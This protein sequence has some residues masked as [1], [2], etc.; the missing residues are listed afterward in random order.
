MEGVQLPPWKLAQRL[1]THLLGRVSPPRGGPLVPVT[2]G[3]VWPPRRLRSHSREAEGARRAKES[4]EPTQASLAP[5]SL[6]AAQSPA[7]GAGMRG[8]F[9]GEDEPICVQEQSQAPPSSEPWLYSAKRQIQ[10]SWSRGC[11]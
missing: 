10:A 9:D 7:E 11:K 2:G 8:R 5:G 6:L 4:P 3:D 1:A